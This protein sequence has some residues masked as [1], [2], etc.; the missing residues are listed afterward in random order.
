MSVSAVR[1]GFSVNVFLPTGDPQGLKVV[2][3]SNWTGRGLVIPKAIFGPS[4]QR[5]ELSR[6]G[7]YLL[8]GPGETS[9]LP[10]VYVGE[11][12]PVRPRLEQH[13]AK[14][15]FWTHAIVFT[16]KDSNLN[17]AHVQHLEARLVQ[18][19]SAAK[20]C[21]LDNGNSPAPPSLSEVD[22]AMA[23]GF[24]DDVLL[25]LP[26]LGYG[27]FE[28]GSEAAASA[29]LAEGEDLHLTAKGIEARGREVAA[30]FVVFRESG[31]VGS[32]RVTASLQTHISSVKDLRDELI[33]QAV[34]VP[35]GDAYVL[36]QD[37][38]FS[39][40]ST[41]AAVLLGRS[42]N[43]RTEWKTREGRTLKELQEAAAGL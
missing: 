37:Y 1:R 4:R 23:E 10:I 9:A 27:L 30:G 19:A 40:P 24:L 32:S 33:R 26:I 34:L 13:V 21:V 3:K 41:A 36:S 43:G 16:S 15:D 31:A 8:V 7:V 39:S 22:V 14:K 18:L 11:G 42:A 17:K 35:Q 5:E 25:C 6:T 28:T 20:R 2:E 38:V 29:P 12:D